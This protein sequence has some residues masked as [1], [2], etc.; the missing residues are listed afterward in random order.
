MIEYVS[1]N[2][3]E[4]QCQVITVTV[5]CIGVPWGQGSQLECNKAVPQQHTSNI[6]KNVRAGD[7]H[8]GQPI[9]TSVDRPHTYVPNQKTTGEIPS[10]IEWIKEGLQ[11][12]RTQQS[13]NLSL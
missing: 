5:N 9:L 1:G 3:F 12:Y 11:T 13:P 8:P 6:A 7:Y 10:K 4:S 2:I